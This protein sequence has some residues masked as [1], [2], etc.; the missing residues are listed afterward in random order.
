MAFRLRI[1]G[2]RA[3]GAAQ[4]RA[5]SLHIVGSDLFDRVHVSP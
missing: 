4:I 2:S 5:L 3:S 1:A